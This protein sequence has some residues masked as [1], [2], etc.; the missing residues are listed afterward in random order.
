LGITGN[1][2]TEGNPLFLTAGEL[3]GSSIEEV[4]DLE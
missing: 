3:F 4:I 2:A 1:S